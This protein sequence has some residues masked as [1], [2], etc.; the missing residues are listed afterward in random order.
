M[1]KLETDGNAEISLKRYIFSAFKR[2]CLLMLIVSLVLF[3]FIYLA[4]YVIMII[5]FLNPGLIENFANFILAT[6]SNSMPKPE[7]QEFF[8][9]VFTNNIG[10]Y[11][12]PPK[13][14]IWT[15]LF[16]A[17]ILGLSFLI[18]GIIV[19]IAAAI[20]GLKYGP[21]LPIA[22][23]LPHGIIEIPAFIIQW[24]AILRWQITTVTLIFNLVRGEKIDK[25]KVK[26]D[27][28][29]VLILSIISIFLLFIAALIE[30]Y[31][32]PLLIRLAR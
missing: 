5:K 32:T 24:A 22:G 1:I 16:G 26:K 7:T 15:P 3:A 21:L 10:C 14:L 9:Y 19:G 8:L 11:W 27:L 31:I 13:L 25:R 17:L 2:N 28:I 18:N 20:L 12:N 30:T 6:Y 29:S 4:I 23:L